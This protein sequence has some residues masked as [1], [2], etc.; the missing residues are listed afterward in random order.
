MPKDITDK[1]GLATETPKFKLTFPDYSSK[2][3]FGVISNLEGKVGNCIVLV[4]FHVLEMGC[5]SM[6]L[7]LG[8]DLM[9]T[10]GAV[11]DMKRSRVSFEN[12]DENVFYNTVP[13]T[14]IKICY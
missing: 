1:L 3:P 12:I 2:L 4:N 14:Y 13:P 10:M 9:S 6:P 8:R 7:L 11:V 5:S